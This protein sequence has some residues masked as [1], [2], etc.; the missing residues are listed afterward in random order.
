MFSNLRLFHAALAIMA[1]LAYLSGELGAAHLW[2][3]YA[4][5]VLFAARLLL[6]LV[7]PGLLGTPKWWPGSANRSDPAAWIGKVFLISIVA[8]LAAATITGIMADRSPVSDTARTGPHNDDDEH[9]GRES[10][11]MVSELHDGAANAMLLFV[12]LHVGYLLIFRRRYALS[13]IFLGGA[14][15]AAKPLAPT[16]GD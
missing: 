7:W 11:S 5:A 6:A 16:D 4:L 2:I 13:M 1:V 15:G 3:G 12:G 9:E 14:S 8:S 10:E